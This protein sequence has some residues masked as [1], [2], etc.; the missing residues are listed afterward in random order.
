MSDALSRQSAGEGASA[1]GEPGAERENVWVSGT[2]RN[3]KRIQNS[4]LL[5]SQTLTVG[6][7]EEAQGGES[8]SVTWHPCRHR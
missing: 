7:L 8:L 2:F 3:T 6:S 4:N 1:A 5:S